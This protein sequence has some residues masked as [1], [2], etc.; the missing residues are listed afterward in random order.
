MAVNYDDVDLAEIEEKVQ[1]ILAR[2]PGEKE[3]N[4]DKMAKSHLEAEIRE[5]LER[6]QGD[7]GLSWGQVSYLTSHIMYVIEHSV[8]GA[9]QSLIDEV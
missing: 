1:E 9:I 5:V 8:I 4:K 6:Y 7:A 3:H 2:T